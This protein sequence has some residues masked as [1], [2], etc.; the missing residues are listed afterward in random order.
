MEMEGTSGGTRAGIHT[1]MIGLAAGIGGFGAISEVVRGSDPPAASETIRLWPQGAPGA[2]GNDP[3]KDV[4]TLTVWRPR[5][6]IATGSA[7]VVCPGGGYAMLAMDHEGRQVAEWLNSLGITAFVLKYRLGPRYHHPA[8]LQDA[9][10]AI[11]TVRANAEKWN[12][13]PHR[14]AILGF[15][16]GGHLAS[17][18]GTHFDSGQPDSEDP[19]ERVS[20][21]PDRMVLV[22][23]VIALA[24]PY[25]HKG[26]LRNLLGD[27]PAQELVESLSNEQQ[28]TKDT[29]P[30]FIAHTNADQGV[31]AENALLFTL[32]LRKAGVPVELHLF[33]RGPHGLGLGGG[34][35]GRIPAEPS[36]QAWPRLGE[37]WLRNQ[38]FLERSPVGR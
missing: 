29:P 9:G 19:I 5:P 6:Q 37:T 26:S 22:Y 11:R 21:R 15:S 35:A 34:M 23:P 20:S 2:K 30:T 18:A 16:A 4:P 17:T 12:L 25:G 13:D 10:R 24:T 28:V 32:A 14:I 33:E 1:L 7:V 27:N 8:M 31:P 3:D 36:F 38:G